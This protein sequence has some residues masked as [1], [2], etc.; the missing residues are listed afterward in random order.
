MR[1]SKFFSAV[2]TTGALLSLA[3]GASAAELHKPAKISKTHKASA[4][5]KKRKA[6]P[7]RRHVVDHRSYAAAPEPLPEGWTVTIKG[8]V[9]M[10]PTWDGSKDLSPFALPGFSMRK[11]G[12]ERSYSSPDDAISLA[13]LDEGWLKA[14]PAG[15]LK[16]P[17]KQSEYRELR[18]VH[19]ID[20][21]LEAGAFAEF[22]TMD[23]LRLRAEVRKGFLGHHGFVADLYADWVEKHGPWTVSFGPRMSL[24]TKGTMNKLYGATFW[25]AAQNGHIGWYEPKGGLKSVGVSAAVTYDWNKNWATTVYARYNRLTGPA[26]ASPIVSNLGSKNQFAFGLIAA[27]SFD[28]G[29]LDNWRSFKF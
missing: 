18:G 19:D 29:G 14:G 23:K 12:T 26:S 13:L 24:A 4:Q 6:P 10:S 7:P 16:G 1:V 3:A 17:R 27:Y 11:A 25:E 5:K 2:L 28:W 8:H 20:W 9:G 22:W 15:R 21:T